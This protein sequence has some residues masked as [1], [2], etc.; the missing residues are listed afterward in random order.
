MDR[1]ILAPNHQSSSRMCFPVSGAIHACFF[2]MMCGGTVVISLLTILTSSWRAGTAWSG[3]F[4]MPLEQ[5]QWRSSCGWT[6]TPPSFPSSISL[7]WET[8]SPAYSGQLQAVAGDQMKWCT[9]GI[10]SGCYTQLSWYSFCQ[11]CILQLSSQS[12]D[13]QTFQIDVHDGK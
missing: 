2:R 1:P 5:H 6:P 4:P 9:W 3:H 8:P 11:C 7:L 12:V 10:S 13:K